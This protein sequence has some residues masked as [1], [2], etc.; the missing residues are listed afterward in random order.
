MKNAHK[1]SALEAVKKIKKGDLSAEFLMRACLDRVMERDKDVRA[2][3]HIDPEKAIE[4]AF[5]A[6]E[7]GNKGPLAGIPIAVKDII[8]TA[9]MPTCH[10]STIYEF[11]Q[12]TVDAAVVNKTRSMGG[13]I[14]GKTVTTEFAWRNPGG[15]C[16]PHNLNHTPG[17]SSSGSAAGIADYQFPLAFGTQTGGSVIRPA[18][19]C[20]VVG[21]KPTFG[22]YDRKGV[23]EL[24]SYL[25]TVGIMGRSVKDV[26][27]FDSVLRGNQTSDVTTMAN[28]SPR[29]GIM[30]P[31]YEDAEKY[32]VV[33]LE[34]AGKIAEKAGATVI[35]VPSSKNFEILGDIHNVIM[36]GDAGR[37]LAWE[38]DHHSE[39]LTQF[40]K[41]NIAAG[42]ATSEDSLKK[43]KAAA[44]RARREQAAKLFALVDVLI[45]LSAPGEAPKGHAFTGDPLFNKVWT[46]LGWPCVT[47]PFETGPSGLPLGVQIIAPMNKDSL[48]L[49][50]SAWLEQAL[51]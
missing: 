7:T 43:A 19:Y 35:E 47:I 39:Q 51:S 38:Y 12:P 28:Q 13:V 32:A 17:G 22:T 6:D 15:T 49:A 40:Y 48:A 31:F 24:S 25:D 18:A 20:G 3:A 33:A 41:E 10:G 16:N 46:M 26:A 21:F 30:V 9:D 50:A 34:A 42:R 44:D 29:I 27:F 45:T 1:L 2:W 14:M 11:N 5:K 8:D 23:K 36:T 37:A 4:R